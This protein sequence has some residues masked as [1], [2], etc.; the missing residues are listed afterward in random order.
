MTGSR[1]LDSIERLNLIFAAVVIGGSAVLGSGVVT[2]GVA[3]GTAIVQ[4]NYRALRRYAER[5]FGH[6]VVG[7][8]LWTAGYALRFLFVGAALAA[9]IWAGAH[10]VG[11]VIGLSTI[12]PAAVLGAWRARPVAGPASEVPPPDDASWDRWNAWLARERDDDEGDEP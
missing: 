12:V 8:R 7:G 4:V 3:A 10:P 6:E 11:L 5:L 1:G 2:A 9:A